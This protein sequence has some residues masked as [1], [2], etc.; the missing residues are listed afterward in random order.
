MPLQRE[1]KQLDSS[2]EVLIQRVQE[3]KS[4]IAAFLMKLEHEY[5]T[6]N[7]YVCLRILFFGLV[8]VVSYSESVNK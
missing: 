2:L 5:E 6:L 3:V 7:W 4:N 1:E 8:R